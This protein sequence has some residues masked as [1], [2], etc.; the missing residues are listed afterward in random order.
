MVRAV[1][2]QT[3]RADG[4]ARH[5]LALSNFVQIG[6]PTREGIYIANPDFDVRYVAELDRIHNQRRRF[7]IWLTIMGYAVAW[8]AL[9]LQPTPWSLIVAASLGLLVGALSALGRVTQ[10]LGTHS[11]AVF[12]ATL[13]SMIQ[14]ASSPNRRVTHD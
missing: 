12:T 6:S 2:A 3:S 13:I 1:M 8:L 11:T 5:F 14:L 10:L 9:I 4:L 7:P